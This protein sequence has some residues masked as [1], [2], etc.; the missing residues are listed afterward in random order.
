M[1]N[2]TPIKAKSWDEYLTYTIPRKRLG[3]F[4]DILEL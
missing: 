4:I 1:F 2:H 3:L